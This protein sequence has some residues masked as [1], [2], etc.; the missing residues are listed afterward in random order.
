ML[1]SGQKGSLKE[2]VSPLRGKK[3]K[4]SYSGGK[5]HLNQSASHWNMTKTNEKFKILPSVEFEASVSGPPSQ[6][7]NE[8]NPFRQES[9][10]SPPVVKLQK[11]TRST[12]ELFNDVTFRPPLT[13]KVHSTG[14]VNSPIH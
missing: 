8:A 13:G 3:E 11:E 6:L 14:A 2:C 12:G 4:L 10:P 5:I 9:T 7:L 1:L